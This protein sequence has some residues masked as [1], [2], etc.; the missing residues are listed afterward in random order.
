MP[1]KIALKQQWAN[2]AGLAFKK[3]LLS[4][5]LALD[6]TIQEPELDIKPRS[7]QH[8]ANLLDT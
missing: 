1:E 8:L 7:F 3:A 4:R 2:S 5:R 6:I